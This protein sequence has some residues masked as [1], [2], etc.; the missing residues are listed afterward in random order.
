MTDKV[1]ELLPV[2]ELTSVALNVNIHR[3]TRASQPL[4]VNSIGHIIT[5]QGFAGKLWVLALQIPI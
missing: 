1:S 5:R 2:K 3:L 4:T